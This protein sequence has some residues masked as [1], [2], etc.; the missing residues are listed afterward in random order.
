MSLN[1]GVEMFVGFDQFVYGKGETELAARALNQEVHTAPFTANVTGSVSDPDRAFQEAE[2]A[3]KC[4]FRV[5][6]GLHPNVVD[7]QNRGFTPTDEEVSQ[8]SSLL[9]QYR[10]LVNSGE[11]WTEVDGVIIDQHEAAR[12]EELLEWHQLCQNKDREKAEAAA[13]VGEGDE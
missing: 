7:P 10:E 2:A 8:A 3:R 13:R 11:I 6:G 12:A 9:E 5:G 4:G 1:L